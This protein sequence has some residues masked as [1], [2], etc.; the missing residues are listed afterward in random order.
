MEQKQSSFYTHHSAWGAY[1]SFLLGKYH[2]GGGFV[3]SDVHIPDMNVYLGYRRGSEHVRMFPFYTD[4]R[5]GIGVENYHNPVK[6]E[7]TAWR[8]KYVELFSPEEIDRRIDWCSEEWSAGIISFTIYTPFF[9]VD[10]PAVLGLDESRRLTSP[11]V[12]ARLRIDN[13]KGTEPVT[14][15]FGLQGMGRTISDCTGGILKGS[16]H[17]TSYGI[18]CRAAEGVRELLCWDIIETAFHT[19]TNHMLGNEGGMAFAAGAGEKKTFEIVLGTFQD[20]II[21]SNIPAKL[22]YTNF[23][24]NLEEV[25]EY[26][27][28]H[29][30]E[31][32]E[33]ALNRDKQLKASDLNHSRRFLLSHGSRSYLANTE[34]LVDN[35]GNI[36]FVV[37][38]GEYQMMN[39][40][41]LTVDQVFWELLYTP[42][43]VKNVLN[44]YA[45]KYY[46]HDTVK[47]GGGISPGGIS[48][49][50]DTGVANMF[51]PFHSSSYEISDQTH[52]FSFMTYEELLNWVLVAALYFFNTKDREWL[53]SVRPVI[54]EV[55]GSLG[56]RDSDND[57]VMD[58]DSYRCR[59]GCEIST[60]DSL[61]QS[62]SQAR[63]NLYLA[64]K[65]WAA[66][67]CLG[68]IFSVLKMP[69]SQ[70]DAEKRAE[71]AAHTVVSNF[72]GEE[73]YLPAIFE[74]CSSSRIV[75]AIEGLIYPYLIG[76][77][78][79]VSADGRYARFIKTLKTHIVNILKPG[80]CI[81]EQS[82]GWK[83]SSTSENTWV[84]KIFLNQYICEEIL[85]ISVPGN[86]EA[87]IVHADWQRRACSLTAA[88]DQVDSRTGA[89]LGSRL[90]PRQVTAILWLEY[91]R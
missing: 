23:F 32:M 24:S 20:G 16:A 37:N 57:G 54:E 33:A 34:L 41:D 62:L 64:V 11:L 88:T 17:G 76:D 56:K 86:S 3:L 18:A 50:H 70:V 63:N 77:I 89:P 1:A 7:D 59:D 80:T 4:N 27:T 91:L 22:Y 52:T 29:W 49:C 46:Y 43:T 44:F 26:G 66:W 69:S 30:S 75:P 58:A 61:D 36:I 8:K 45:E 78:N 28:D 51:S 90:Y 53:N 83:L 40:L 79:A 14:A 47:T 12:T 65:G 5:I 38:E 31:Y 6:F 42:W 55:L 82:G 67:V 74:N 15:L 87:D 9:R 35:M 25:L 73:G 84:S 19:A 10:D 13:S 2:R 72:N 39:T 81:D 68:R 85:K 60:Y 21:T 48:F 71:Q